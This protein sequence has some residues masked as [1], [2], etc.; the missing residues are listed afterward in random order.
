M[1][2]FSQRKGIRP[3]Q[4]A[5]QRE[6]VDEPLRNK[7]WTALKII[8]WDRFNSRER[9]AVQTICQLVWHEYFKEPIDTLPQFLPDYTDSGYRCFRN[10]FF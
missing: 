1:P 5:I 8:V 4:N 10:Y 2:L 7:L 9:D 6:A 3:A